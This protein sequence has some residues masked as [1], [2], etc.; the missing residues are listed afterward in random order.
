MFR[1]Y[2]YILCTLYMT[3]CDLSAICAVDGLWFIVYSIGSTDTLPK[4][5]ILVDVCCLYHYIISP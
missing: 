5:N 1:L 3:K 4:E 2:R